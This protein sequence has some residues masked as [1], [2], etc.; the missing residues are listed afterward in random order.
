MAKRSVVSSWFVWYTG[1]PQIGLDKETGLVSV[2]RSELELSHPDT[3]SI[4]D[5][6]QYIQK[7]Y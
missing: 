2:N 5:Y 1:R 4:L 7:K 3:I 6:N